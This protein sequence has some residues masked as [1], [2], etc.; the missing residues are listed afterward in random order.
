[1]NWKL[2]A[3]K[4]VNTLV[5]LNI[6]F[7]HILLA[8][9]N[10]HAQDYFKASEEK[11]RLALRGNEFLSGQDYG[12]T[13]MRV[14]LLGAVGKPGAHMIPNDSSL[15]GLLSYAGGPGPK[16]EI[17]SITIKRTT[18]NGYEIIEYDLEK[19][20]NVKEMR[21]FKLRPNDIIHVP[22]KKEF[23]SDNS[24]KALTV[25][26]TVLG[27]VVSAIVIDDRL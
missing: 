9:I 24:L 15:T 18:K 26:S 8:P 7:A 1:M 13:L 17:G 21:D 5:L 22:H 10:V 20:L 23:L 25:V 3:L 27:I 4:Q 14:H 16:A 6:F 11:T 19:F 12:T 2:S